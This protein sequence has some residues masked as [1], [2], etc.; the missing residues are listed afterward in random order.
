[1]IRI[2]VAA[3]V[4]LVLVAS[5]AR[6]QRD[7]VLILVADDLGVDAV[8]AYGEGATPPPTPNLDALAANGVLFRNAW[9]NPY[10]SPSRA[11]LMTG[12]YSFRTGVGKPIP[13]PTKPNLPRQGVLSLQETTLPELLDLRGAGYAH[14]A[15][16]KWHLGDETNGGALGPNLAGWSHY[17]GLLPGWW[18]YY[19]WPRTVDGVTATCT[20]YATTE[21][22]DDAL[23][24]IASVPEPWVCYVAFQAPHEPYHAPPANLHSQSLQGLD[25]TKTQR[26]FFVAMVQAMDTEI[27]RL[28]AG[29]GAARA[30][31]DVVFLGDNGTAGAVTLPPFVP[32][33]AKGTAYE[34]ALNVP[35]IVSGPAVVAPGREVDA[36]V[37]AVDVFATAVDLCGVVPKVPPL[38]IDGVSFRG[39][40]SNPMQPELRTFCFAEEFDLGQV[41]SSGF[42]AV[43]DDRFKLIRRYDSMPVVE[44]M[45]DLVADPFE[46]LNLLPVPPTQ[47]AELDYVRLAAEIDRLRDTSGSFARYGAVSCVGSNGSPVIAG[48]GTPRVGGGY[49]VALSGGARS[50]M[51]AL[52]M[53]VSDAH[54][55]GVSLPFSLAPL[56]GGVGCS[57]V[58]SGEVVLPA[59]SDAQG[60]AQVT[61]VLPALSPLVSATLFHMWVVRDSGVGGLGVTVSDGLRVVVGS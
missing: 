4:A 35:L 3:F 34:G 49:A 28:L 8:G 9:A 36:L 61:V 18:D 25:P 43:R 29:L 56:G 11:C 60:N 57:V 38:A 1:M 16:G 46:Q 39:Y 44:E 15:I 22:V 40:L 13:H 23:A 42:A 24:W 2:F 48:V 50:S 33:H 53:G 47:A 52:L 7:N 59:F 10:C 55:A 30:R 58:A 14:A 32:A 12:R 26:P 5:S 41:G 27:G 51:A 21:T 54:W 31:T 19:S 17:A 37:D 45:Y 6:G 20:V